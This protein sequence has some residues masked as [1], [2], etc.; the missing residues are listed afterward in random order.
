MVTKGKVP[1]ILNI[2]EKQVEVYP[3]LCD[4]SACT[5]TRNKF[6]TTSISTKHRLNETFVLKGSEIKHRLTFVANHDVMATISHFRN[7]QYYQQ[8]IYVFIYL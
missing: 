7:F 8:H 6:R 2:W 3:V 4:L 5:L 1:V